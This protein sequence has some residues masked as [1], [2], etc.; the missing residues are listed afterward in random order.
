[1]I[2]KC[3]SILQ[4]MNLHIKIN[5]KLSYKCMFIPVGCPKLKWSNSKDLIYRRKKEGNVGHKFVNKYFVTQ[6]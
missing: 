4:G 6:L 1:M 2:H 3:V 5:K